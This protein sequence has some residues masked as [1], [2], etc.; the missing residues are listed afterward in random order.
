MNFHYI[1]KVYKI[2]VSNLIIYNYISQI[3][4]SFT[5]LSIIKCEISN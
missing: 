4:Q 5:N 3:H 2:I 1:T